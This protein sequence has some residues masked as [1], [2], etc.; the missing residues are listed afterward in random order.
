[1]SENFSEELAEKP[2]ENSET[3]E[4]KNYYHIVFIGEIFIRIMTGFTILETLSEKPLSFRHLTGLYISYFLFKM[5]LNVIY[6]FTF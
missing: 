3:I 2:E 6:M 4:L 1:M 5:I